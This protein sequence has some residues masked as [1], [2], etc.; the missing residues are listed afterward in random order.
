M[1]EN[2]VAAE[3]ADYYQKTLQHERINREQTD[4]QV[5]SLLT[6]IRN[7]YNIKY[8]G[9]MAKHKSKN[10]VERTQGDDGGVSKDAKKDVNQSSGWGSTNN[11]V[12]GSDANS[13]AEASDGWGIT[14]EANKDE[15]TL[16]G[17]GTEATD[18]N[19]ETEDWGDTNQEDDWGASKPDTNQEEDWGNTDSKKDSGW[20]NTSKE[21]NKDER[22]D[23]GWGSNDQ[24]DKSKA[25][26]SKEDKKNEGKKNKNKKKNQDKT[27]DNK[28][29]DKTND[30]KANDHKK[31]DKRDDKKTDDKT[32]ASKTDSGKKSETSKATVPKTDYSSDKFDSTSKEYLD[33]KSQLLSAKLELRLATRDKSKLSEE[34][35]TVKEERDN[36][37]RKLN[38][39]SQD[40]DQL[41]M[42]LRGVT[43]DLVSAN[44]EIQKLNMRIDEIEAE[45]RDK[46]KD[47]RAGESKRRSLENKY[48]SYQQQIAELQSE[49][50]LLREEKEDSD[51]RVSDLKGRNERLEADLTHSKSL[52]RTL[53]DGC[54]F[55]ENQAKN[56]EVRHDTVVMSKADLEKELIAIKEESSRHITTINKLQKSN[57]QISNAFIQSVEAHEQCRRETE[58]LQTE[59][60]RR[61]ENYKLENHKLVEANNQ[62]R[63]LIDYIQKKR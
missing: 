5:I 48:R 54:A 8:Q 47:A 4:K 30:A 55:V 60:A 6:D 7:R 14:T 49:L 23:S 24:N 61:L 56:F 51:R 17:W 10:N 38:L 59:Y 29:D 16:G 63:K 53:K 39:A 50:G 58:F 20:G 42:K 28:T 52:I 18:K 2:L 9:Y 25:N 15:S 1:S 3:K 40:Q 31:D 27:D 44:E 43:I 57:Q 21:S 12:W 62:L 33:M 41:K 19:N 35:A 32:Y 11:G 13:K 36:L 46:E 34:L 26:T 22:V 45:R 37:E